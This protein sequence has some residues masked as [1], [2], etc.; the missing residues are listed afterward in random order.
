MALRG[1]PAAK[2]LTPMLAEAE[3]ALADITARLEN[4]Q[5]TDQELLDTLVALAAKVERATAVHQYRFSATQAYHAIVGQ[6]IAELREKPIS[7]HAGYRR[8][9]CS[10]G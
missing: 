6:R 4:K 2:S 3:A 8:V 5:A 10:A 7:G 1:L 9:S